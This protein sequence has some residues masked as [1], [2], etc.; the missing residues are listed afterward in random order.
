MNLKSVKRKLNTPILFIVVSFLSLS[1][2]G[3]ALTL[4]G[5]NNNVSAQSNLLI[6]NSCNGIYVSEMNGDVLNTDTTQF[7]RSQKIQVGPFK[8]SNGVPVMQANMPFHWFYRINGSSSLK[9]V[10][11]D[12]TNFN[13]TKASVHQ[14]M[15]DLSYVPE[16]TKSVDYTIGYQNPAN[17]KFEPQFGVFSSCSVNVHMFNKLPTPKPTPTL[18]PAPTATPTPVVTPMPIKTSTKVI[19]FNEGSVTINAFKR[20][21]RWM[22]FNFKANYDYSNVSM[23]NV[24][25]LSSSYNGNDIIRSLNITQTSSYT[26]G[27]DSGNYTLISNDNKVYFKDFG[28]NKV[29]YVVCEIA[30]PSNNTPAYAATIG[31]IVRNVDYVKESAIVN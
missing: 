5:I 26:T 4:I 8:Y 1:I 31:S 10:W 25:H 16:D 3:G 22:S 28:L 17:N 12:F 2:V 30:H 13:T 15:S 7:I 29:L 20:G 19:K 23:I 9:P 24:C 27:T 21:E 14:I 11:V 18:T 6:F